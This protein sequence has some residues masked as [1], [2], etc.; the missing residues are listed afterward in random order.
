MNLYKLI[1]E[2]T[3][4]GISNRH[5]LKTSRKYYT[6]KHPSFHSDYIWKNCDFRKF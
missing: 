3:N 1:N 5:A 2:E 4:F 6:A